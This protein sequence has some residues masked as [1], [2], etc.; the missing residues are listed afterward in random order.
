[1]QRLFFLFTVGAL[2]LSDSRAGELVFASYNLENY[3]LEDHRGD[4][5]NG[6]SAPKSEP[7]L[8]ALVRVIQEIS[9]DVLGVCEMGSRADFT[10][11]QNRLEQ[12]HLG[13]HDFEYVEA[14][15]SERHLALLSRVPIVQ[16]Q[17][18]PDVPFVLNGRQEKVKRGFLDVT[19][20]AGS[21]ELRL[22][23]VHLKSKREVPEDQALL[24][25]HEAE[26][27]RRHVDEILTQNEQVKLLVY[28]D[29]NDL[30]NEA[31]VRAVAG[32]ASS[33]HHLSELSLRDELGD[34]WTQYWPAAD[35]YS[36]IDYLFVNRAL[37]PDVI[38]A[39]CRVYRSN[40]W[41]EA[42][43]HRPIVATIRTSE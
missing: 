38:A 29:F 19:L 13:Y 35:L 34:R 3:T 33:A 7:A 41:N 15:D 22:I 20:K 37:Q 27:L 1:M 10:D 8:A 6:A 11:L 24:R 30:K 9:P 18:R 21:G 36:R 40:F 5:R 39:K 23:G 12:A 31:A 4:G 14:A 2:W 42:S 43:D 28:G 17:S 16:R 32:A 25:R 26:E